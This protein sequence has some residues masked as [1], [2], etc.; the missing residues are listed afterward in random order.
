MSGPVQ[1]PWTKTNLQTP[2]PNQRPNP[3]AGGAPVCPL[4]MAT[5]AS[6]PPPRLPQ[7]FLASVPASLASAG[8]CTLR[9]LTSHPSTGACAWHLPAACSAP[10]PTGQPKASSSCPARKVR[11]YREAAAGLGD[12]AHPRYNCDSPCRAQGPPLGHLWLQPL[13]EHRLREASGAAA[14]G[15]GGHG[16]CGLR[17]CWHQPHA[18]GGQPRHRRPGTW[19][20]SEQSQRAN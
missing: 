7:V 4:N 14:G 19:A 11:A 5:R 8:N 20:H 9:S 18:T 6:P 10:A 17:H 13:R 1:W 3:C 12:R 15:H 16:L 2:A